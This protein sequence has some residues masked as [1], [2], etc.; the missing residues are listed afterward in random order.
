M[1][2]E[3]TLPSCSPDINP[4]Q[5]F[6]E[7]EIVLPVSYFRDGRDNSS[8]NNVSAGRCGRSSLTGDSR[9]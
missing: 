6:E 4:E 1:T 7:R 5:G 8:I 9:H 2:N 3:G